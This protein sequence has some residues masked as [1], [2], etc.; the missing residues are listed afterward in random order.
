MASVPEA[1][2]DYGACYHLESN[3]SLLPV[4]LRSTDGVDV[5]LKSLDGLT[6]VFCYPCTA[7]AN[8]EFP[9]SWNNIPG[10]RGCT[11]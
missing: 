3:P 7:Q 11:P 2:R 9:D 1:H 5:D 8:E 6:I 10:A 4:S